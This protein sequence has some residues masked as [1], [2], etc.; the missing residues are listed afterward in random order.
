MAT[1]NLS[2]PVAS[3]CRSQHHKRCH[4]KQRTCACLCHV[5]GLEAV[6]RDTTRSD[7]PAAHG[8]RMTLARELDATSPERLLALG[9]ISLA[10]DDVRLNRDVSID[11]MWVAAA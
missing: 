8:V 10:V 6:S 5:G 4:P 3:K 11:P 9:I 2:E 7:T 1:I